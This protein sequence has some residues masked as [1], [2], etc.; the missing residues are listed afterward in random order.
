[1]DFGLIYKNAK[2]ASKTAKV[3]GDHQNI[4]AFLAIL[5]SLLMNLNVFGNALQENIAQPLDIASG[6]SQDATVVMGP[7]FKIVYPALKINL[8]PTKLA[9]TELAQELPI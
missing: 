5:I 2:A 3:V 4:N 9:V 8:Y 6:V 1:M 7:L